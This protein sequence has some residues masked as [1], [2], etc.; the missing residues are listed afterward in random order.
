MCLYKLQIPV[1]LSERSQPESLPL[2]LHPH[3]RPHLSS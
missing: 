1:I 2:I 3:H